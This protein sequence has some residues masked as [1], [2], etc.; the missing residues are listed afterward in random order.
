MKVFERFPVIPFGEIIISLK[1]ECLSQ[2]YA[3]TNFLSQ[4][5]CLK[6]ISQS[7]FIVVVKISGS[8]F[9]EQINFFLA[10]GG[11]LQYAGQTICYTLLTKDLK[12]F[13]QTK[14]SN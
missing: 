14:H 5:I 4:C 2:S 8:N 10:I 9:V 12:G 1:G 13:E 3:V 11:R 6:G 7:F